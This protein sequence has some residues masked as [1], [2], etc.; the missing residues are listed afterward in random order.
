MAE[1]IKCPSCG[2]S[3]D[4]DPY[5]VSVRCRYCHSV[6][7]VADSLKVS[8]VPSSPP[9]H[10]QQKPSVKPEIFMSNVVIDLSDYTRARTRVRRSAGCA[11]FLFTIFILVFVLGITAYIVET[12]TGQLT[13]LL[14][15]IRQ[16]IEG[17]LGTPQSRSVVPV[18]SSTPNIAIS[19]LSG[20]DA[21][22]TP[23]STAVAAA[24]N[25]S[26]I[27]LRWGTEGTGNGQFKDPRAIAVDSVGS[28][29]VADY[30]GGRIQRFDEQGNHRQTYL[31]EPVGNSQLIFSLAATPNA[32]YVVMVREVL[33]IDPESGKVTQRFNPGRGLIRT[34]V[35]RADGRLLANAS[36]G[37]AEVLLLDA[38]GQILNQFAEDFN[39]Q[40]GPMASNAE[41][42]ADGV[43]N[44][45][46]L[47]SGM[48]NAVFVFDSKGKFVDRFGQGGN[49][50]E[51]FNGIVSG[52]AVGPDG[53]I[54]VG[55]FDGFTIHT[56]KGAFVERIQ[57]PNDAGAIRDVEIT[58]EG[59][60]F[61]TTSTNNVIMIKR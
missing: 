8:P 43:G 61:A 14:N 46:A 45:Y 34:L 1:I 48:E 20:D 2:S 53:N 25:T 33:K 5:D 29:Y 18:A 49:N 31:L 26:G 57:I 24:A 27:A 38:N 10:N 42:A 15:E 9:A 7:K 60:L 50:P 44:F 39:E 41:I 17:V 54:Y 19:L 32:L 12:T 16:A 22:P 37:S 21:S 36:A 58:S 11:G 40:L 23:T 28:V 52:I 51:D 56:P 3:L 35:V 47:G 55:D 30:D 59:Y 4:V 6:I 13:P